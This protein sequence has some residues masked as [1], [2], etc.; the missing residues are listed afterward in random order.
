MRVAVKWRL[1]KSPLGRE[2]C[3][4]YMQGVPMLLPWSII[5]W[6]VLG[7]IGGRMFAYR[8]YSPLIGV[9]AGVLGG[10]MLLVY[11]YFIPL[12][13]GA[14]EALAADN[15]AADSFEKGSSLRTCP[16]CGRLCGG[17]AT[18]CPRCN[19]KFPTGAVT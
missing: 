12:T 3:D 19:H 8:G 4:F 13:R 9:V 5:G 14:R 15:A 2:F 17:V 1:I 11:C 10:P 18:F 16:E 6:I 7:L